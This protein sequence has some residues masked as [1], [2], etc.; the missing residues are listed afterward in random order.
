[1]GLFS[2]VRRV[3][4]LVPLAVLLL[5]LVS[6]TVSHA[7]SYFPLLGD[8]TVFG[9]TQYAAVDYASFSMAPGEIRRV[10]DQLDIRSRTGR[11]PEVDNKVICLDQNSNI[12]GPPGT[13]PQPYS[14]ENYAAGGAG[15]GTNYTQEHGHAYQWNVSTL[16][17]APPQNP[18][19]NYFCQLLARIDPPDRMTVLAPTTGETKFGTWL[20][21]SP[22]NEVGAQQ[23]QAPYCESNDK[24][25][26][27]IGGGTYK[28]GYSVCSYLGPGRLRDPSARNVSWQP[29]E[30]WTAASN[31]SFI[32]GIATFQITSCYHGTASC[33]PSQWGYHGFLCHIGVRRCGDAGGT[34]YLNIEQL[35]PNGSL[36]QV[37]RVFSE[38]SSGG[39]VFLSE[40]FDISNDQHHLPLYY[41]VYAPVSQNC[42]GSRQFKVI[43]HIRWTGGNPVKIDGGNVNLLNVV[44][45]PLY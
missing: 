16:I 31:A 27:N 11:S 18:Q 29:D 1:M 32:D 4:L 35:Y 6:T 10:T 33:V 45:S 19:E 34:S 28:N 24:G 21:V 22:Q 17:Q 23:L 13:P 26:Q 39:K 9:S 38:R 14:N 25:G 2:L 41:Q 36:C 37:N 3:V 12:I 43:L 5:G 8:R 42:G 15:T 30:F 7:A 44:S 20:E 40:S